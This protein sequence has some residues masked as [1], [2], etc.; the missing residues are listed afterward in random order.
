[1]KIETFFLLDD[2]QPV[3]AASAAEAP[4]VAGLEI[5]RAAWVRFVMHRAADFLESPDIRAELH[6]VMLEYHAK[7]NL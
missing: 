5:H 1:L 7:W 4:P 6:A 2:V 3:T